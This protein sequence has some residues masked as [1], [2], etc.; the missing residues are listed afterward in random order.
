MLFAE[1]LKGAD[2]YAVERLAFQ[3][4]F[5]GK[6]QHETIE[7]ICEGIDYPALVQ[8]YRAEFGV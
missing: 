5:G 8:H 1:A 7:A 2:P 4:R 6:P 3:L